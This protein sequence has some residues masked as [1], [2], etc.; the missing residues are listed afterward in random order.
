VYI[1]QKLQLDGKKMNVKDKVV[2]LTGASAGIGLAAA[3]LLSKHGAKIA[4]VAR[5]T[6]KLRNLSKELPDSYPITADL[7]IRDQVDHMVDEA[8]S[9]Y[10]RIDILIN[11]AG[12]GI[13]GAVEN[14]DIDGFKKVID[15]NVIGP[16]AAM[17]KVIPIMREQGG[18]AIVNISSMLSKIY[19]P[20]LGTYASTK[21]A[22][23][24]ITITSRAELEKDNIIVSVV[25]PGMT[26][27][28]FGKNAVKMD[29]A[30]MAMAPRSREGM[31]A[32][33]SADYVAERILHAIETGKAEVY[34]HEEAVPAGSPYIE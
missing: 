21:Y 33:D 30:G 34:A 32:P 20:N 7:S 23:N 8:K 18:G 27:T 11:N 12:R 4:L 17:L 5:S 6:D 16:V 29:K 2:I 26:A 14:T 10:G 24:A 28:D 13:Y 31:P 3:R 22:L 25:Y 15:L 1:K 9:H 19:V